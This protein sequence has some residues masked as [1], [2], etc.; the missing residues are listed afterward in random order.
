MYARIADKPHRIHALFAFW[1]HAG[2]LFHGPT[3]L[4]ALDLPPSDARFPAAVVLHAM[5]AVGSMYAADVA[6]TP[7]H[8]SKHYPCEPPHARARHFALC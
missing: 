2:R 5:C 8:T 6:P 1:L 4:A 7:I 3:F